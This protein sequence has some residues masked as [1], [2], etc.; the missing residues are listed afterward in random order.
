[1]RRSSTSWLL[2]ALYSVF[3]LTTTTYIAAHRHLWFDEIDTFF[4][5]T[6]PNLRAIW[7]NLL[8][9]TD[10]Q[11]I[12][13]Y[14]PTH[15]SYLLFGS[16]SLAIRLP[17]VIPFW[18]TTLVLY[19]AVA[20][21]T[22]AIYGFIAALTPVFTVAFQYSFEARPYAMVLLF[23]ACSFVAWQF[24]KEGRRRVVS[25]P[26]LA[27]TLI[28]AIYVHYNAL[29]VTL[30]ILIGEAAY[31][32]RHR[33]IDIPVLLAICASGL[34]LIL[35]LPQIRAI[36]VYSVRYWSHSN[37]N[38]LSDIYFTLTAKPLVLGMIACVGFALWAA[39]SRDR[40][41]QIQT[42]LNTI[43][44]HELAASG[45]YLLLPIACFI[46]SF[47]TKALHYRYVIATV[48]GLATFIPYTLWIF[49]SSLLNVT[50]ILCFLMVLNLL[51]TA[52][53]R[54][55]R[56][57]E[58]AWGTYASHTELFDPRTK[59][60]YGSNEALVLGDGPFMVAAKY[61]SKALRDKSFYLVSEEHSD[62]NSPVVFRGL[63]HAVHGPFHIP[64]IKVFE[65]AHPSFLMYDP[66]SWVLNQLVAAGDDVKIISQV[67]HRPLY[68]VN[69]KR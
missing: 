39:L 62:N 43:P 45:S 68:Q 26:V 53:S 49:R 11:P 34:S 32:F 46:L 19:Y 23:S 4:V 67:D 58:D 47:Y 59:A 7:N 48:I 56:P 25:V 2:L 60:I 36:H 9:A 64:D 63:Q 61:G 21:R 44:A 12:G 54:V 33:K 15:L 24:A 30:P 51:Y 28:A 29:L 3:L 65:Q 55:R 27:L 13:F 50:R 42:D 40:S 18:L 6:L 14:V 5:G 35:L 10:G 57:D 20:R 22:S 1:M 69:L 38:T 66:E 8:L 41:P 31:V 52:S 37:F 17:A 16:S